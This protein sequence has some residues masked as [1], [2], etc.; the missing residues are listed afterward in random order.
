MLNT[1]KKKDFRKRVRAWLFPCTRPGFYLEINNHI[2]L[3][4]ADQRDGHKT[5]H[6]WRLFFDDESKD[7][8][9]KAT[10]AN[11]LVVG[12][13]PKTNQVNSGVR[14][15]LEWGGMY[16][17]SKLEM[18]VAQELERQGLTYFANTRGRYSLNNCL[19]S[20]EILNGR[21][22][23][24]FLVFC[25]GKCIILQIDA[26]KHKNEQSRDH[27]TDRVMLKAGIPSVRFSA[28]DC[29]GKVKELVQEFLEMFGV[30]Q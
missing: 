10:R 17:R 20:A 5:Q 6:Y 1:D 22:E 29:R 9:E 21:L 25:Q 30:Q 24:D 11:A 19:V 28:D 7:R 23:V 15:P 27:A 26:P 12:E 18:M 14:A 13:V 3:A 4:Y 8:I 2:H 16:F